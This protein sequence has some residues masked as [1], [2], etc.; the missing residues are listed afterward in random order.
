MLKKNKPELTDFP[1][2]IRSTS[3]A[4]AADEM[5]AL[6]TP[7]K[8]WIGQ[9]PVHCTFDNLR[10][11]AAQSRYV[12]EHEGVPFET[13]YLPRKSQKLYVMFSG[14]G[15]GS[16]RRYPLFLRWKYQN[17]LGGSMLCFDDPM[18]HDHPE[19]VRVMWYYGTKGQS[20]LHNI[21]EIVR[22]A[23]KQLHISAE[24]VTFVGSSGG[25]YAALYCANLLDH[26]SAIAM[27]PQVILK[28]WDYPVMY[29]NFQKWGIDLASE[30]AFGRN[31]ILLTNK[32]SHFM[33]ILN[34][35][36][37]KEFQTQFT[38]FAKKHGIKPEFG[39]TQH[40]NILTWVHA[41][42]YN[43]PHS[44]NPEKVGLA[45]ADHLLH[46]ARAGEDIN[47]ITDIS[48]LANELLY[49]KFALK[50]A[51][52]AAEAEKTA[53]YK[54]FIP[55]IS[56]QVEELLLRRVPVQASD[57][58]C[59][60]VNGNFAVKTVAWENRNIAYYIG[61]GR[62]LR[63]NVFYS[64]GG[65]YF[66]MK[67]SGFS[68]RFR[69]PNAVS[70]YLDSIRG[71]GISNWYIEGKDDLVISLRLRAETAEQQISD[72]VDLTLS[73]LKTHLA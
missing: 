34:A 70:A 31:E 7:D 9:Q 56:R 43:Q 30:D 67:C 16:K 69:A 27:N 13:L 21:V 48:L 26:S 37:R 72:F 45:I 36:S 52:E 28:E 66:R 53:L 44:A 50:D 10:L 47:S 29:D 33:M 35:N 12:I 49:E 17:Y 14:G 6:R 55:M 23:M 51:C 19:M 60:L 20:Y 15:S 22:K 61:E 71:D 1:R 40:G 38:P 2:L 5:A 64:K 4:E 59:R 65:F 57:V 8:S 63:Y 18:Y 73:V 24:D 42:D 54:F 3:P 25:G 11:D 39:I 58:I 46:K 62:V 41:T 68:Q 32:T